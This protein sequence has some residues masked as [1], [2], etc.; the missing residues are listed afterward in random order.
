[1]T[2]IRRSLKKQS[3]NPDQYF[4]VDIP[5]TIFLTG[6]NGI[7]YKVGT[8]Q[9]IRG[10]V[11]GDLVDI[12]TYNEDGTPILVAFIGIASFYGAPHIQGCFVDLKCGTD[13]KH[14]EKLENV[15]FIRGMSYDQAQRFF[16]IVSRSS[17]VKDRSGVEQVKLVPL[18][19]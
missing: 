15:Y 4:N 19:G 10:L 7:K 14:P 12:G 2:M 18:E 3:V 17:I 8:R 1:M 9:G 16:R 13:L 11:Y 6:R 5:E